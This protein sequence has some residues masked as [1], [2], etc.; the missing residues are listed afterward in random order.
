MSDRCCSHGLEPHGRQPT[1]TGQESQRFWQIKQARAAG[2]AGVLL[3]AGLLADSTNAVP[4]PAF[5]LGALLV[6]GS[7]FI[8]QSLR[9]LVR[10]KLGVG[11]LMTIAA[12]GAVALGEVGEA[13]SLAFLFSISEALEEYALARTRGGLRSLLA[14]V[15]EQVTVR[16]EQGET[17]LAPDRLELGDVMVVRP[18]DRV[19]TDGIVRTGNSALDLSAITG[20]SVPVEV[21]PGG[22]V[23]AASVNGGGLLEVEVTARTSDSSLARIVQIVEQA[24]QRK[25][26]SQRL[27]ERI[28]RPLVPGILV[29]AAGVAVLG[30]LFGDPAL[31]IG[32]SLVV[33]VAAAPCAFAI[34]VPVTVVAGVGA[35]ARMGALVKGGAALEALSQIE[36]IAFDKTGTLT[37]NRPIVTGLVTSSG[38]DEEALLS[39]AAALESGSEHPLADAILTAAPR[40]AE[41]MDIQAVVGNGITGVVG[42]SGAR[43]GKPGFVHPGPL[44][45]AVTRLQAEGCTVVLVEHDRQL[46]GAIAVRDELRPEATAVM[47]DLRRLGIKRVVMLTGDNRLTAEALGEAAGVDEV[48]AE[49]LPED[50]L[51]IV[52][53]LQRTGRTAMVGDGINDAPALAGAHVGIAMGAV[54]SD[55]AIEAADVALMGE[56]LTHLPQ[57]IGHAR[58]AGRIMRQNLLLSGLILAA[59]IPLAAFGFLGLAAV[60]AA[61][62][63]AEVAV[64]A[65][66]V[67]AGRTVSRPEARRSQLPDG[68]SEDLVTS[69][70]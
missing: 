15:P 35:A 18:G 43:L 32:R 41:A 57:V 19:A 62:E 36:V 28:A 52:E 8:P 6:G 30:A 68:R 53:R 70:R 63:L 11:T 13:A 26:N 65:N 31:W 56:E 9:A 33:L 45:D 21:A 59:L 58:R 27:A 37:R 4:G 67:R 54:G 48:Q 69:A 51:T 47:E 29:A 34:S 23:F 61:H 22:Q 66:G 55:V 24:Q 25:G 40:V 3:L 7:T 2:V 17:L 49:L 10:G 50:K 60:V 5:Y 16:S 39:V 44:T 46:Q 14:L 1:Q 12:C 64:I 38:V 20:E 42:G